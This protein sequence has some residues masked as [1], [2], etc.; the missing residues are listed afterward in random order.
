MEIVVIDNASTVAAAPLISEAFPDVRVLTRRHRDGF[1]ANHNVVIRDT[2]SRYVLVL[3]DDTNVPAGAID[4]LV[5]YAD[6]HPSCGAV[7]PRIIRP[8][9]T[10]ATAR[11]GFPPPAPR[12]CSP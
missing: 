1:G 7:G 2:R 10:Q 12:R 3:N 6:A 9:G 8:D 5:E 11:S 4:L